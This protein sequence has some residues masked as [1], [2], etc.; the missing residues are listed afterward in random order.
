MPILENFKQNIEI[1]DSC[2]EFSFSD[3]I[4][5]YQNSNTYPQLMTI[6]RMF[7]IKEPNSVLI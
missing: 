7:L 5:I 6:S 4:L 2:K 1:S 3:E